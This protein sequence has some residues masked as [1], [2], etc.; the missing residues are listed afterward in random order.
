[1][2]IRMMMMMI[3]RRFSIGTCNCREIGKSQTK[4][5]LSPSVSGPVN[6]FCIFQHYLHLSNMLFIWVRKPLADYFANKTTVDQ[7]TMQL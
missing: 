7:A 4:C 2:M 1:M 5:L 6:I 3:K